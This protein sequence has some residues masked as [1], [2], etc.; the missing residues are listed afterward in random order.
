MKRILAIGGV[1]LGLSGLIGVL[2]WIRSF[3]APTPQYPV[4]PHVESST[5]FPPSPGNR[6]TIPARV[7][8]RTQ[9][10]AAQIRAFYTTT[11]L[12]DH[13]TLLSD[14]PNSFVFEKRW[15]ERQRVEEITIRLRPGTAGITGTVSY[16]LYPFVPCGPP[17][18]C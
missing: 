16:R 17:V 9:D 3:D 18:L 12:Q 15:I 14:W 6:D 1:V 10:S 13:W 4:Y 2:V 8:F 7:E 5:F 11:L